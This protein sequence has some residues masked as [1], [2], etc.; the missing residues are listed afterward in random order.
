[1]GQKRNDIRYPG[2]VAPDGRTVLTAD[3]TGVEFHKW[4][5]LPNAKP[6]PRTIL[7]GSSALTETAAL[8]A[9]RDYRTA[10]TAKLVPMARGGDVTAVAAGRAY[11]A[12]VRENKKPTWKSWCNLWSHVEHLLLTDD[13]GKPLMLGTAA[14]QARMLSILKG[15]KRGGAHDLR[16]F[17]DGRENTKPLKSGKNYLTLFSC[18]CNFA[19]LVL[20]VDHV[21]R[22]THKIDMGDDA[23]RS[24]FWTL[25]QR[26][27][28]LAYMADLREEDGRI[29]WAHLFC[30][31]IVLTG[32]RKS[33]TV[34]LEWEA[35]ERGRRAPYVVFDHGRRLVQFNF[36]GWY[37]PGKKAKKRGGV[38]WL[39]GHVYDMMLRAW[40]EKKNRY[41]FGELSPR[42]RPNKEP[43]AAWRR[44]IE[45]AAFESAVGRLPCYPHVL[46]HTYCTLGRFAN[47]SCATLSE[48]TGTDMK[49][50]QDHY[51]HLAPLPGMTPDDLKP[52]RSA[53]WG[54]AADKVS[55]LP[56]REG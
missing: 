4:I 48:D 25:E 34:A 38:L 10:A 17:A 22:L 28:A 20:D 26:N 55:A 56:L 52:L 16:R 50:I 21:P 37:M 13:D 31:I 24:D 46:K 1:V 45:S 23:A 7:W 2:W 44:V 29:S 11:C 47:V 3:S 39:G 36:T 9:Y 41:V 19:E 6:K 5:W 49:T 43:E 35:P 51:Q 53:V 15:I 33:A 8:D 54:S 32:S 12:N 27:A 30:F 40:Q 14:C 42:D 18:I